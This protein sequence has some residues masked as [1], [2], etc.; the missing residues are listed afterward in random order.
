MRWQEMFGLFF[1]EGENVLYIHWIVLENI[2]FEP[3]FMTSLNAKFNLWQPHLVTKS[4]ELMRRV[5]TCVPYLDFH[6]DP[7]IIP[8]TDEVAKVVVSI[9]YGSHFVVWSYTGLNS[10][11]FS[12]AIPPSVF[13][14]TYCSTRDW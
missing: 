3:H 14:S 4:L 2:I 11:K 8:L 9:K 12:G 13:T 6:I 10:G 5:G 1:G 7:I